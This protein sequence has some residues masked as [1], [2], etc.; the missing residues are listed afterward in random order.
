MQSPFTFN[1]PPELSAKEPPE[2]RGLARDQVRLMIIERASGSVEHT[3]FDRLGE[4]LRAGDLLVFNTSRTLPAALD[5]CAAPVGPC[6][7]IRLAEHL[8]DDSWLAL[9]LCQ[10]GDPFSCGLRAGMQINFGEGLTA[11]I[12]ERDERIARL[13]RMRFSKS[14]SELM[15]LLYRLGRPIR[16]E[17]VSAPWNL[18]YYQ[19]VY[20]REPGS[21]EMPSAGRAF[22][23]RLLFD[24]QRRGIETAYVVLHTGLSSYMDDELDAQHPASE[25]EYFISDNAAAKINRKREQGGRV[26]AV[27]TTV[28]RALEAVAGETGRVEPGHGYTRL[29]VTAQHQLKAVDGL[30]TGLHE[31]EAS[32]LDLLTAF[33]PAE[34]IRVAYLEAVRL[35]YLWH[36]FGDLN[37][38]I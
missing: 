19:T 18:D 38:I 8:P 33:L 6:I 31:P 9:L 15:D 7:E 16:Y 12:E 27:G 10:R 23:W 3:R 35:G 2:R 29:H 17:Y 24:L 37:L 30:L 25:E 28:V 34:Q 32:H 5:G 36:E 1:L 20:A 14:G 21:A 13:W 26:V 11:A 4:Y 22:T